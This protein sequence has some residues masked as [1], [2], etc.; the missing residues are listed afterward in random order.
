MDDADKRMTGF[1]FLGSIAIFVVELLYL[2]GLQDELIPTTITAM[3]G[4]ILIFG[5]IWFAF[6]RKSKPIEATKEQK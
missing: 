1:C 6:I 4:L 3:I 5:A 2:L